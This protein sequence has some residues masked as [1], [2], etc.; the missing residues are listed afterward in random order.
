[1]VDILKNIS[2]KRKFARLS[3]EGVGIGGMDEELVPSLP[4]G[5]EM[6]GEKERTRRK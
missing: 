2:E 1:M 6:G 3:D 5:G 4:V